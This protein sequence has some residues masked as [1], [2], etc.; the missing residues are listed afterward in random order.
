MSSPKYKRIVLKLSGEAL[1]G[2]KGYGVDH[3]TV[4]SIAEDVKEAVDMGIEIAIVVGGGN[5][6]RGAEA[7]KTG[8]DRS[9]ADYV[10]MLAT[11]MNSIVLQDA[12]ESFGIQTRVQTAVEMRAIAEPYIRR[13][14]IRHLEKGR[15]VIFGA[16]KVN[17]FF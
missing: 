7:S 6:W 2:D 4:M 8:M 5:I 11:V 3:A 14:A 13:K 17:P 12:L 15:V 1:S 10:G 16:G 9:T